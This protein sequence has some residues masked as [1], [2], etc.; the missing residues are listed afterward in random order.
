MKKKPAV[1]EKPP[2]RAVNIRSA[3]MTTRQKPVI[4]FPTPPEEPATITAIIGGKRVLL[5]LHHL[6]RRDREAGA[7]RAGPADQQE[8]A[9]TKRKR[10]E[11][12]RHGMTKVML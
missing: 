5:P 8:K 7:R 11:G 4:A 10:A 12:T 1:I 3:R 2:S 6:H 9:V